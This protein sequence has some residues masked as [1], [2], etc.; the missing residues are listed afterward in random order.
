MAIHRHSNVHQRVSEWAF[1]SIIL[2]CVEVLLLGEASGLVRET[3]EWTNDCHTKGREQWEIQ[4]HDAGR[5]HPAREREEGF[6]RRTAMKLHVKQWV[7]VCGFQQYVNYR[8][9]CWVKHEESRGGRDFLVEEVRVEIWMK[10]ESMEPHGERRDS[11]IPYHGQGD[12]QE[13]NL[14]YWNWGDVMKDF[15]GHAKET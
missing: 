11:S 2:L 12:L 14:G 13:M 3:D 4:E 7:E 5:S 6:P 1:C 8:E 9:G 15:I 10:Q